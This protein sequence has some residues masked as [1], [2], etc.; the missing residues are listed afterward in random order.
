MTKALSPIVKWAG[1]KRWLTPR[2]EA[3]WKHYSDRRLVEPFCGGLAIALGLQP[4]EALLNDIN[5]HLINLYES[6]KGRT[7][8]KDN[9]PATLTNDSAAY[10]SNRA[11][12]NDL[13]RQEPDLLNRQRRA[14]LFYYLNR[15]GFNGLCR[16]NQKGGYNVPFGKYKTINYLEDF[17]DY[18]K[19]F[20]GWRF[21]SLP[22]EHV[23]VRS[24]DFLYVDPP[25]DS[26]PDS[27]AFVSYS[28]QGFTWED[29]VKLANWIVEKGVPA[30]ASNLATD[31]ILDLYTSLGFSI[32]LIPAPRKISCN[33]DRKPVMEMFATCNIDEHVSD[34]EPKNDGASESLCLAKEEDD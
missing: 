19:A 16:F 8:F 7:L 22:F 29:Q 12:F 30:I 6:V 28:K 11:W 18:T 26:P 34:E 23:D 20:K 5:E 33:G 32:E 4:K 24:N 2:A 15:T 31:R 14:W 9:T 21:S 17:A 25:Y 3:L 27:K 1:G 10:Y 13:N